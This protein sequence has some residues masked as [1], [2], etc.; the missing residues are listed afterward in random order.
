MVVLYLGLL[1]FLAFIIGVGIL[2]LWLRRH[3][4]K[5]NAEKSSRFRRFCEHMVK[6]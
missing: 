5:V 4:S 2:G 1:G 6:Q 3:P